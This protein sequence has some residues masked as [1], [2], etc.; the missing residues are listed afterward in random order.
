MSERSRHDPFQCI[1][2]FVGQKDTC[3]FAI[4]SIVFASD[5]PE[6]KL[7]CFF[8]STDQFFTEYN[9]RIPEPFRSTYA[10]FAYEAMW[11]IA[12]TLERARLIIV[13]WDMELHDE[14]YGRRL[15]SELFKEEAFSVHFTGPSVSVFFLH[16]SSATTLDAICFHSH[17]VASERLSLLDMPKVIALVLHG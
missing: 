2:I 15:V 13:G 4:N 5:L 17:R 12:A 10:P 14:G 7:L 3:V 1:C 16:T 9:Q 6:D 8:Q 11:A